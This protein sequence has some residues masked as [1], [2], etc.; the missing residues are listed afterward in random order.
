MRQFKRGDRR[1]IG[2]LRRMRHFETYGTVAVVGDVGSGGI[3]GS[4]GG[5]GW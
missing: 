3:S 1:H 4:W 5:G 2:C